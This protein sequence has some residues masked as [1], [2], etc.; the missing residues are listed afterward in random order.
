MSEVRKY[1]QQSAKDAESVSKIF[2]QI[3]ILLT[4]AVELGASN[5]RLKLGLQHI[6]S[7]FTRQR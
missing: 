4:D 1:E 3:E 7:K 6:Y 5:Q 2:E